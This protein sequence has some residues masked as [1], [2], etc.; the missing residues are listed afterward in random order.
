MK[1]AT[2]WTA[3]WLSALILVSYAGIERYL[4]YKERIVFERQRL[5]RSS[6][7]IGANISRQLQITS[8]ALRVIRDD[9]AFDTALHTSS[10]KASQFLVRYAMMLTGVRTL[11]I[12]DSRGVITSANRDGLVGIDMSNAERFLRIS[13]SRAPAM[14]YL[15]PPFK[16]P[17]GIYAQSMGKAIVDTQGRFSGYVIAIFEPDYFSDLLQA[18][19]YAPDMRLGVVHGE[20]R[21]IYRKPDHEMMIGQDFAG[22]PDNPFGRHLASGRPSTFFEGATDVYIGTRMISYRTVSADTANFDAPIL[23]FA[24]RDR[25]EVFSEFRKETIYRIAVFFLIAI[26]SFLWALTSTR[27]QRAYEKLQLEQF[28]DQGKNAELTKVNLMLE[29]QSRH[30]VLTGLANRLAAN[31]RLYAEFARFKRSGSCY[32]VMIIDIDHFK[33]VNDNYGHAAGDQVL[34]QVAGALAGAVRDSDFVARFGGEEFLVLLPDTLLARAWQVAEKLRLS[35]ESLPDA[36][37]GRV[38]I[39]IGVAAVNADDADEDV[40]VRSA[41]GMLYLAKASGRNCVKLAD[42]SV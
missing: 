26:I 40:A 25:S 29:H 33:D 35:V 1:I 3:F 4:S 42:A 9:Y 18:V 32:A 6:E 7:I 38:T 34:L 15:A 21:V 5:E 11:I 37:F 17:L 30:D 23:V 24:G 31:D 14:T 22:N 27:R 36:G 19:G 28:S 8:D 20:G 13:K 12:A 16:T 10:E 41:D 2:K 39:S